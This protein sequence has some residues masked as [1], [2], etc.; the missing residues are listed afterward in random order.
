MSE[1]HTTT[2]PNKSTSNEIGFDTI[3]DFDNEKE[4]SFCK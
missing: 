1:L 3:L 4:L 2:N